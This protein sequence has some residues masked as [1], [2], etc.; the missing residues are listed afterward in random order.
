MGVVEG[1]RA[2]FAIG[3][4]VLQAFGRKQQEQGRKPG[5]PGRA[6]GP[7]KRQGSA[8]GTHWHVVF[9]RQDVAIQSTSG[10]NR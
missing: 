4:R 1:K 6:A 3:D 8:R 9:V 7:E 5:A 2:C 10:E